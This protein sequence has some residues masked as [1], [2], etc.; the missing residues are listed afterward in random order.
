[1]KDDFEGGVVMVIV[2]SVSGPGEEGQEKG[3]AESCDTALG[4]DLKD[5][6]P[7]RGSRSSHACLCLR[8]V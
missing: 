7:P 5:L 1:M 2:L 4:P 6:R 3:T 8:G